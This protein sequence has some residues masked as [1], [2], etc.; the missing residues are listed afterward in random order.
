[1]SRPPIHFVAAA[2]LAV[3]LLAASCGSSTSSTAPGTTDG[4]PT[5]TAPDAPG[6][7]A[8]KF[9]LVSEGIDWFERCG[10]QTTTRALVVR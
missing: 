1:M 10:S 4:A 9:D 8:L 3:G 6:R 2:A 7:Y 5:T